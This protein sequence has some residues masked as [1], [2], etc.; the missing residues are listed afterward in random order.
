MTRMKLLWWSLKIHSSRMNW[1]INLNILP[2]R[3]SLRERERERTKSTVFSYY[4]VQNFTLINNWQLWALTW[5]MLPPSWEDFTPF[6][7]QR[8]WALA[9]QT[10]PPSFFDKQMCPPSI[11]DNF[12]GFQFLQGHRHE[13]RKKGILLKSQHLA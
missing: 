7:S 13:K 2:Y 9:W 4:E 11:F 3:L 8:P 12:L 6:D 10:F 1:N 5:Q